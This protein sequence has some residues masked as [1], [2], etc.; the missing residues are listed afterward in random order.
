[1]PA[2]NVMQPVTTGLECMR[3]GADCG[4]MESTLDGLLHCGQQ[5]HLQLFVSGPADDGE[6]V[7]AAC[8]S[9]LGRPHPM[10]V[11]FMVFLRNR[12]EDEKLAAAF[13]VRL[14]M[15]VLPASPGIESWPFR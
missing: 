2:D 3:A 12:S 13:A 15:N 1:M 9:G 7:C 14:V 4:D 11:F 10:M 8:G 5:I 6:Q